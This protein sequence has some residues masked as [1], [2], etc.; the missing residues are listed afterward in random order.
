ML[1]STVLH[2][3]PQGSARPA[4]AASTHLNDASI[5]HYMEL[6]TTLCMT[7]NTKGGPLRMARKRNYARKY[8]EVLPSYEVASTTENL[9]RTLC[10]L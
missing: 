9:F 4:P 1:L 6:H 7:E 5:S 10:Q 8:L 2:P 3:P